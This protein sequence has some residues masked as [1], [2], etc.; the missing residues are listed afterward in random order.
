MARI[1]LIALGLGIA[2]GQF[3]FP[4]SLRW[5][6]SSAADALLLPPWA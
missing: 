4:G 5:A 2:A 3:L 1:A 6:F